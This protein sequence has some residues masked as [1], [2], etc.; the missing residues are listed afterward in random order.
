MY[1]RRRA[2]DRHIFDEELVI[3]LGERQSG[4]TERHASQTEALEECLQKLTAPQREIVLTA[5]TEQGHIH[6]LAQTRGE[7]PMALYKKLHRIRQLLLECVRRTLN[8]EEW[9]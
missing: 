1:L 6:H 3:L 8:R 7:T 9:A 5:Y 4:I 2:R